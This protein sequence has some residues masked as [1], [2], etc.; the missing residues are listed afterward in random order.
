MKKNFKLFQ[1]DVNENNDLTKMKNF[2]QILLSTH[3]KM[4]KLYIS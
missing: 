4:K 2:S 3:N 1:N